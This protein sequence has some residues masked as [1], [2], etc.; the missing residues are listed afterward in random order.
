MRRV[1]GKVLLI[2]N[3][4]DPWVV[5][6]SKLSASSLSVAIAFTG[7]IYVICMYIDKGRSPFRFVVSQ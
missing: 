3:A 1:M 7:G 6:I 2:E 4:F 5:V